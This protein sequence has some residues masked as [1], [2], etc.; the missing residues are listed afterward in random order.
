MEVSVVT[1]T[2][3]MSGIEKL[4]TPGCVFSCYDNIYMTVSLDYNVNSPNGDDGIFVVKL[5]NNNKDASAPRTTLWAGNRAECH[6]PT[7][8][9]FLGFADSIEIRTTEE[10]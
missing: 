4:A 9:T 2:N 7:D 5:T 1:K 3:N 6:I 10:K 8:L